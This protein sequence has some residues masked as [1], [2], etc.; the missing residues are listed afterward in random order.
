MVLLCHHTVDIQNAPPTDGSQISLHRL[1]SSTGKK[2]ESGSDLEGAKRKKRKKDGCVYKLQL[3][4]IYI[5]SFSI[6]RFSD[7]GGF[8]L[9]QS[10]VVG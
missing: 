6:S 1:P 2:T 7:V 5:L 3:L 10:V 8:G 4:S 9:R